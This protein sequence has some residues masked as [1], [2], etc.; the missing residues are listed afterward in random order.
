MRV[1]TKQ[2]DGFS[3]A[4]RILLMRNPT[5]INKIAVS[6]QKRSGSKTMVD[7]LA[8]RPELAESIATSVSIGKS[9]SKRKEAK[10]A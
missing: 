1:T 6:N 3:D 5:L 7:L 10:N 9:G 2:I 8:S 4:F